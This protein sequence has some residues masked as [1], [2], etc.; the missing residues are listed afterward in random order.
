MLR[1][2]KVEHLLK[3]EDIAELIAPEALVP[4]LINLSED[5]RAVTVSRQQLSR[6]YGGGTQDTFPAPR[7]ELVAQHGYTNFMCL[8]LSWNPHAPTR[9]GTGGLF[10]NMDDD[11][12]GSKRQTRFVRQRPGKWLYMGEYLMVRK[13]ILSAAQWATLRPSVSL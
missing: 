5:Q 10:F 9:P 13:A 4:F 6:R 12:A 8:S 2:V 11:W 3:E 7:A 1:E